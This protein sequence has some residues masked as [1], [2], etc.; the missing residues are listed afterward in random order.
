MDADLQHPPALLIEMF[1]LL[2]S[3]EYD[4]AGARRVDRQGES[5][6]KSFFSSRFYNVINW[7]TGMHLVPGMTDYRLMRREVVEAIVSMREKE[8]FTKGIYSWIG[9]RTKWIEYR[10]VERAAGESK[11]SM[12]GL[13]NYAKSG[14]IAFAVAPLR[15][16]I[17]LGMITVLVAFIYAVRVLVQAFSGARVWQDTTT[18]ILLLLFFSGVIITILGII[19]EYIARVYLEVKNRPIYITRETNIGNKSSGKRTS[20]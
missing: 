11:W 14:F 1:R 10:N 5:R 17:Y 4:C 20:D 16:V 2:E 6:I 7:V 12:K 13:W 8:R 9:F 18:I 19:G 15:G 3:G